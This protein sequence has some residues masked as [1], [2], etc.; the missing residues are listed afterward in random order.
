[1]LGKQI[2]GLDINAVNKSGCTPLDVYL[3]AAKNGFG[4]WKTEWALVGAGATTAKPQQMDDELRRGSEI[5]MAVG[6]L[7][8]A[9]VYHAGIDPPGGV[10]KDNGY[11]N[12]PESSPPKLV[13]HYAGQ[14]IMSSVDSECFKYYSRFIHT[15]F[16]SLLAL[17]TKL[18]S[19]RHSISRLSR[20]FTVFLIYVSIVTFTGSYVVGHSFIS[21]KGRCSTS[22]SKVGL[23]ATI[24]F[25]YLT[26]PDKYF[27]VVCFGIIW[28]ILRRVS[29][30]RET[31][32]AEIE[33]TGRPSNCAY[34]SRPQ[35][36]V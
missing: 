30:G 20:I 21:S 8:L 11:H 6:G 34:S 23:I 33:L 9:M 27:R 25:F 26:I 28:W 24:A 22:L 36:I 35:M 1:M 16:Y 13:H 15:S 29:R 4:S 17:V 19:S 14:S 7:L 32:P 31:T 5:K 12:D 18:F 3:G 2:R 10:Y